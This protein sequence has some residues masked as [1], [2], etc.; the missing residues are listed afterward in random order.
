M[1]LT[2]EQLGANAARAGRR[3]IHR[4]AHANPA[5]EVRSLRLLSSC[6]SRAMAC[7]PRRRAALVSG[8]LGPEQK[9]KRSG[10]ASRCRAGRRPCAEKRALPAAQ[11]PHFKTQSS[12]HLESAR[13][14]LGSPPNR[15]GNCWVLQPRAAQLDASCPVIGEIQLRGNPLDKKLYLRGQHIWQNSSLEVIPTMRRRAASHKRAPADSGVN[16]EYMTLTPRCKPS[17]EAL[18]N[19]TSI[20]NLFQIHVCTSPFSGNPTNRQDEIVLAGSTRR[21]MGQPLYGIRSSPR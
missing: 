1:L 13:Q 21:A 3:R 18:C 5:L 16:Q 19:N 12:R 17:T 11:T 7:H 8:A 15:P 4:R 10:A 2:V 6:G 20:L 9:S 14:P